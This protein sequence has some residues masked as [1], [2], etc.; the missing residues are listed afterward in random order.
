MPIKENLEREEPMSRTSPRLRVSFGRPIMTLG[1][2]ACL[3]LAMLAE[4]RAQQV[5]IEPT[6][7]NTLYEF[8]GGQT[9]NAAGISIFAGYQF[10]TFQQRIKRAVLHFDVAGAVPAG[11]TITNA[12]LSLTVTKTRDLDADEFTAHRISQDWGDGTSVAPAN[13][14]G[15]GVAATETEATWLYTFYRTT[16]WTNAGGDFDPNPSASAM[17]GTSGSTAMWSSATLTADVQSFLDSPSTNYG[18]LI[19]NDESEVWTAR[20]FASHENTNASIRPKLTI[21]YTLDAP[22]ITCRI[23]TVDLASGS[24]SDILTVN[25]S[26]GDAQREVMVAV[27]SP[28]SIDM[29]AP[30]GGPAMANFVLYIWLGIP[31]PSDVQVLPK[32]VGSIC[33]PFLA[34]GG[35]PQPF[36]IWNNIGRNNKLGVADFP[37]SPAPSNVLN[38]PPGAGS[39]ADATLQGLIFDNNSAADVNASVTN[40]VVLRIQ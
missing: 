29:A 37:S 40:A 14:G 22:E 16:Q 28:L 6:R 11:A 19:K 23:G 38:F 17:V 5:V 1:L 31:T 2:T 3:L 12:T 15:I 8:G 10:T 25:G 7:D 32:N 35:T 39:P 33:F 36:K 21:D 34:L 27:G 20:R 9:G 4:V 13:T 24:P 18:W 30:P 26:A